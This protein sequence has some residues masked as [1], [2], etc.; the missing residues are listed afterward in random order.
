MQ[1]A[2]DLDLPEACMLD[3]SVFSSA[4]FLLLFLTRLLQLS[5]AKSTLIPW[6]QAETPKEENL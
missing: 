6:E 1:H 4:A 2:G 5:P 3:A